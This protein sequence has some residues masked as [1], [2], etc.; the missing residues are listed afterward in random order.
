MKMHACARVIFLLT[1]V[2][3]IAAAQLQRDVAQLKSWPAPLFWQPGTGDSAVANPA[4]DIAPQA[5]T[6]ANSLV[7][8]GMTP[9]RVVDTRVGQGFTGGFGPPSLVGGTSRTFPIQSSSTCSIPSIAQAYS[10]NITIAP[11]GFLDYITA[12]PTGQPRPNASTLNGYVNTVIANAA[13][14]PAGTSGSVDVYASQNT[15]LI[16]D[17]NGY[18]AAQS[19]ITLALGTAGTPSLSFSGDAGTGI[20]SSAAGSL[21]ITAGGASRLRVQS[22]GNTDVTGNLNVSNKLSS[23]S[24]GI[25]TT[26]PA[27]TLDVRGWLTLDPGADPA[28][29]TAASGGEHNRYL[30]LFNSP[31]LASASGLKAGGVLVSDDYGY[32]SPGKN[33]MVVRG[34]VGIGR[35]SGSAKLSVDAGTGVG[36]AVDL[37]SGSG[38]ALTGFTDF[39]A[40]WGSG[41]IRGVEGLSSGG[42]GVRGSSSNGIGVIGLGSSTGSVAIR[43]QNGTSFF[44]GNTTP[45]PSSFGKG[46]GLGFDTISNFGYV[47]AAD[48]ATNQGQSLALN[49]SGGNVGIG[50]AAPDRT[51]TVNGRARVAQIPFEESAAAVCYNNAGDLLSCGFSSMRFK[52]NITPLDEGLEIVRQLRP[53]RFNWKEDERPDIGLGAEDVAKIDPSLAFTNSESE[54][55]GV[56]YEKLNLLLINAVKQQQAQI[57]QL[58]K[59]VCLDHPDENVCK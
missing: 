53:I 20:Y 56:K 30:D 19:G 27:T 25:G 31:D 10:F 18:Y 24:A 5:Q 16:I 4:A 22:N 21:N 12:W 38:Y 42:E 3:A 55:V 29:F 34:K 54:V 58:K 39:I 57:E 37:A 28:L 23:A 49:S 36:N 33:D 46:V 26:L 7:F 52:T 48:Y 13:I 44:L 51:L 15:E 40:L 6:P 32:A 9:C 14:V 43:G 59:L 35:Q 8:V 1:L 11:P 41:G 17:I 45:L 2:P 50:T 47:F